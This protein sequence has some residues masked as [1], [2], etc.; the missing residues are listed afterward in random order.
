LVWNLSQGR[1]DE[2]VERFRMWFK[3]DVGNRAFLLF[4]CMY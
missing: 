2:P 3:E 1:P 4:V